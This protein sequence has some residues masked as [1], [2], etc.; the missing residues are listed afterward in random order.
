MLVKHNLLLNNDKLTMPDMIEDIGK[1]ELVN[2]TLY[3]HNISERVTK[4]TTNGYKEPLSG[5]IKENDRF[6]AGLYGKFDNP[7]KIHKGKGY[8]TPYKKGDFYY[9]EA[10][11]PNVFKPFHIKG[12]MPFSGYIKAFAVYKEKTPDVYLPNINTLPQDKQPLLPPE[13]DYKEI[14]PQ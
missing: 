7:F 5:P 9:I 12:D 2:G 10:V 13:G 11:V 14:Q 4:M 1:A 8:Q 6:F 3:L